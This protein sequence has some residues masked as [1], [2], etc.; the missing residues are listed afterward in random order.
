MSENKEIIKYDA[1]LFL[2]ELQ[3][4]VAIP[5]GAFE[6]FINFF[7]IYEATTQVK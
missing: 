7:L 6:K 3:K 4:R 1:A 5:E 2:E